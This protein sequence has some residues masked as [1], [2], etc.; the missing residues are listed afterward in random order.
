MIT[1]MLV[2][3]LTGCNNLKYETQ[4]NSIVVVKG[5]IKWNA[6][7]NAKLIHI[8][9]EIAELDKYYLGTINKIIN[10]YSSDETRYIDIE[11]NKV[12]YSDINDD[13]KNFTLEIVLDGMVDYLYKYD[14]VKDEYN[15]DDIKKFKEYLLTDERLFPS[16]KDTKPLTRKK[17]I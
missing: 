6:F 17:H 3:S 5:T 10:R 13:F 15:I 12:V 1:P 8:K 14:M 9:N 7:K 11:T 2:T 16:L 4:D